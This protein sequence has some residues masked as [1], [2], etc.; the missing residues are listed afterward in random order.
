MRPA[1]D[2]PVSELSE[3]ETQ[4]LRKPTM[5]LLSMEERNTTFKEV[6]LGLSA[7]MAIAEAKRCLRCDKS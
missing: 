1:V 7:E 5:P 6:Q 4:E 2:V 3:D